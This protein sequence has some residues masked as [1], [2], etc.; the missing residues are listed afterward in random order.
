[1]VAAVL[2]MLVPGLAVAQA[3]TARTCHAYSDGPMAFTAAAETLD[4]VCRDDGWQTGRA[5]TWVRF[6]PSGKAPEQFFSTRVTVFE[7]VSIAALSQGR[8]AAQADYEPRDARL[9]PVGPVFTL[10]L[11]KAESGTT[12]D[13]YAVRIVRPH[14]VTS[15]SEAQLWSSDIG[16]PELIAGTVILALVT[17]MLVMPLLF[18][19][20][21]FLVLRERFVLFHAGMVVAMIVYALT[22]GGVLAAFL[23]PPI[24]LMA[25]L[26]PIAWAVGVGFGGL[27]VREFVEA[28]ALPRWMR[29]ALRWVA[30]WAIVVPG[31]AGMQFPFSQG[32]DNELYFYAFAPVIPFYVV[33]IATALARGSRAARFLAAAWIPLIL[34]SIERILRGLGLYASDNSTD[35]TLFVSLGIEVLVVGLGVADRF[36]AVRRERDRALI[37]ARTLGELT[38]RDALT[39]LFNR[40]AIEDRFAEF[41]AQGFTKLAVL[42]LDH[43]K[44][45]NDRFGHAVGDQVLKCVGEALRPADEN[46][47]AFRMGG[48]EFVL[49]LRGRHGAERAEDRRQAIARITAAVGLTDRPVTASMGLIDVPP[50]ALIDAT[51]EALYKQADRLLYEAKA[52]GRDRTMSERIRVFA[53]RG[54][55]DRRAAA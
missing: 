55:P 27:F 2:L 29:A 51:F 38:E 23:Q 5:V 24:D 26:G 7:S 49:L 8:I 15:G 19:A 34:A 6:Q 10:P 50:G 17:G 14:S 31:F 41:R 53:P 21:F 47:L 44:A 45:I 39:G 52:A 48:E 25:R 12:P 9:V 16:G 46:T 33:V 37:E 43:F 30:L 20:M 22:S 35:L 40:R 4:W 13:A 1:M 32:Y 54:A 3:D 11:P 18:D 42:D 36:L 28:D